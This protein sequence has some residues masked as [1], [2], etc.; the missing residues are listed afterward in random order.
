MNKNTPLE[1]NGN[2][3]SSLFNK[4]R[5]KHDSIRDFC[6]AFAI[7]CIYIF[8]VLALTYHDVI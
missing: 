7:A 6:Y 3:T 2:K 1:R 5:E 4:Q 8:L